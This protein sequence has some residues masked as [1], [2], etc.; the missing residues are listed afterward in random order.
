[1]RRT[2]VA[3]DTSSNS[4]PARTT[5]DMQRMEAAGRAV[6]RWLDTLKA[7]IVARRTPEPLNDDIAWEDGEPEE[8]SATPRVM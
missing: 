5:I 8:D 1:M 7:R 2:L 4:G 6:R 3:M